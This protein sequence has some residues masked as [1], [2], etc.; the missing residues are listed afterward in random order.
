L[1]CKSASGRRSPARIAWRCRCTV[2]RLSARVSKSLEGPQLSFRTT[3][4][5]FE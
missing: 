1:G 2:C 4:V 3:A 5:L